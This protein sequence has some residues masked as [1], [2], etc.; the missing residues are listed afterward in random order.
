MLFRE[1]GLFDRQLI[2]EVGLLERGL[3]REICGFTNKAVP[4][5]KHLLEANFS[6]LLAL[7]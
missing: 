3:N 6:S 4:F 1:V 5:S 2:R 7:L